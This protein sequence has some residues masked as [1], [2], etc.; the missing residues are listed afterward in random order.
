MTYYIFFK[1]LGSLEEFR[2]NPH[3]KIPP[4]NF[5]SLGILKN[6]IFIQKRIFLQ[7]LAQSA[8][9]PASPPSPTSRLVP[10]PAPEQSAQAT[11]AGQPRAA[12]MVGPDYLHKRENNGRI[13]HPLFPPLSS[14]LPLLQSLVTGAFNPGALKL[15]QRRPLKALAPPHP[16]PRL[17]SAL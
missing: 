12:P 10:P 4:T 11:T 17:A 14:A 9:R 3:I 16:P 1:S 13:T 6:S 2:K 15:L 7:L 8:Q 5:Q